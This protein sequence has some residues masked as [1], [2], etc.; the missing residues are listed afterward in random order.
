MQTVTKI[1]GDAIL[2]TTVVLAVAGGVLGLVFGALL[3]L[4]SARVFRL[5]ERMGRVVSPEGLLRPL[6]IPRDAKLDLY[7]HSRWIGA[8]LLACAGYALYVLLARYHAP[9]L[10]HAF[11]GLARPVVLEW[12]VQSSYLLLLGANAVLL[13]AGAALLVRPGLLRTLE[14]WGGRRVSAPGVVR[15]LDAMHLQP[16]RFVQRRPKLVGWLL[17]LGGAYVLVRLGLAFLR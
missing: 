14:L 10:V 15:P 7:R 11:R 16:D 6:D 5:S 8:A 9:S 1:L 4:D 12:I 2:Q 3:I 13:A 17:L